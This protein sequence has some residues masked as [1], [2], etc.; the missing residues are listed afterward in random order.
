VIP[1]TYHDTFVVVWTP[2]HDTR[3]HRRTSHPCVHQNSKFETHVVRVLPP[4]MQ[5]KVATIMS[6]NATMTKTTAEGQ[7]KEVLANMVDQEEKANN[8]PLEELINGLDFNDV[9]EDDKGNSVGVCGLT[10]DKFSSKHLRMICV[11]GWALK[12][13]RTRKSRKQLISLTGGASVRNHTSACKRAM[14]RSE[15]HGRKYSVPF[16]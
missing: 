14:L 10:W 7:D 12:D 6:S 2:R 5:F 9:E 13:T 8:K 4:K 11:S 15:N 3:Y 1:K 16:D